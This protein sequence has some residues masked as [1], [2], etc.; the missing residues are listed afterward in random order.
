MRHREER[1]AFAL[2]PMLSEGMRASFTL[3]EAN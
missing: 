2:L 1:V 3:R